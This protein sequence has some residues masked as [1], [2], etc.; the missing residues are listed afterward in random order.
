M[1]NFY[2]VKKMTMPMKIKVFILF[3]SIIQIS[4]NVYSQAARF[5]FSAENIQVVDVLRHIEENSDYRFFFLREQVDVERKVTIKIREATVEQV[6]KELFTDQPVSFE[7]ANEALIVL[8]RNDNP[9]G[10]ISRYLQGNIQQRTVSG[11]VTDSSGQPLPGVTVL[12]KG[13]T[14]GT[15]TDMNG[16]YFIGNIPE[17]ATL[18]F[19]FVGMRAQ[20]MVV[21]NQTSINVT[22]D[23]DTI[24]LDEVVVVGY[25]TQKKANLTGSVA[26]IDGNKIS[27]QPITQVSQAL[28]GLAPGLTAIQS[29]GQP[30]NDGATLRIRGIGSIGA[31]NDPLI[32]IDGVEGDINRLDGDD[33]A[34]ISVLKDAAAAAIYGSRASNGVILVTTKRATSD[35]LIVNY[36]NYFGIQKPTSLPKFLGAIDFLKYSGVDQSVIDNY[37]SNM[38]TNPDLYPDT[39]WV[40]ELFSENG[41]Q[42]YH[43]L[44]VNGGTNNVKLL[45]SLS[46][47]DQGS[48]VKSYGL[49]RYS[50]RFNSD[51]AFTKNF[52]LVFDLNLSKEE[53]AAPVYSLDNIIRHAFR[54]PPIYN[55]VHSDGSWGDGWQGFN[56]LAM[57]NAGGYNNNSRNYFRGIIRANYYPIEGLNFSIMYSPE[58][59]DGYN[60]SF[61]KIYRTYVDWNSKITRNVP[62]RNGLSQANTRTFTDNFNALVSY[63]KIINRHEISGLLGSEFIKYQYEHFG[64]SRQDFILQD[65]QVLNA[66][67]EEFDANYGT[68][69]HNGLLSYFGRINYAF[70]E[71]FLL[72]ANIRRD[73]SSRFASENRT[74]I[75]P[76][77]SAGW[78][79]SEENIV[80]SLNLFSDLKV[81]ASWGQLGNQQV[82]SDF[83]YASS[84]TIGKNNYVFSDAK[85]IS[86][87]ATQDVLAN[88]KIKWETT[89]TMNFGIDAGIL[90]HR[91][92]F[93]Y[94]YYIRKTKNILLNLPIPY[95]IGLSPSL[96]N[97]GNVEN[98]G[99]DLSLNW[100]DRIN[101]FSY[102]I[103]FILSDVENKVTN[104]AGIGPI[105]TGNSI[106]KVGSPIGMIYGFESSGIF[107]DAASIAEAPS[108][109]G[110]LQ[111]GNIQF[112]DQL[113]V[114]TNG[115][116]IADSADG[117]INPDDRVIL[118]NPFPRMSYGIDLFSGFKG[119]DFSVSLNGVGK[120]DVLLLG[121]MVMPL[122]NAGKIQKWHIQEFW[123][124]ENTEANF[125]IISATSFGSNDS[126]TSSTWVFN[127]SYLRLRNVSLGYTFP[128]AL[129][130]KSFF[131]DLRIYFSGQNLLTFD[132][133][134]EGIDPLVPNGTEG[135]IFPI[136][137]SYT[138]GLN[139]KF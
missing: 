94:E 15:I 44:S 16:S 69:T 26:S 5:S 119:F 126:Q 18:V 111:V 120:R 65:Y 92:T 31:S 107:Q 56:P 114:D 24:G 81:R 57:V 51:I 39:D 115:D 88:E 116:G 60:K 61:N 28:A 55:S 45:A 32:L 113:T 84:I 14:H 37:S 86:T 27:R 23:Y 59:Y 82:G 50:G 75:F 93:T 123:S 63:N 134:P 98:R 40:N 13:T 132:K 108:Q 80:K 3:L 83:P 77:F 43:H 95:V 103:G 74:A 54:I 1:K 11:K 105:I 99:W 21:G 133:L 10:S 121:D 12:I 109:F 76:S 52:D 4:G 91:L 104:L 138:F 8:T 6:L 122:Y 53:V 96:Q 48:N 101:K 72:E 29:S 22:L 25:G 67:S 62:N 19:T 46:Y 17:D 106:I 34:D 128:N 87:G 129:F 89:E 73:A 125:P 58:Y 85:V 78:R 42:Q 33:I 41:F 136:L 97:A 20:E 70:N 79:L 137:K 102:G 110:A 49:T 90:N 66:G 130:N 68:A 35:V 135:A 117:K 47:T 38:S 2:K 71:R 9:L 36:R 127:A 64:A 139:V 100:R 118:G 124:P 131:D 112:K 30:G 7:F